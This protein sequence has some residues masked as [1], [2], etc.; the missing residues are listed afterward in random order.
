MTFPLSAGDEPSA[1]QL[2]ETADQVAVLSAKVT[3]TIS[4]SQTTASTSF[5]DLATSGPAQTVTVGPSGCVEVVLTGNL[6]N[7][8][9][10]YAVM[11]V[12]VS[13]ATTAAASDVTSLQHFGTSPRRGSYVALMTGLTPG[14]TTFTAKYRVTGGTG[15][16]VDR[17]IIVKPY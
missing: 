17:N 4:T 9:G 3:A 2:N 8:A 6:S 7:S 10:N 16:F 15:T 11:G 14:S 5:V 13:G 1:D 12:A